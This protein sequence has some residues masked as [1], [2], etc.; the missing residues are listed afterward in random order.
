MD[1]PDENLRKRLTCG[2]ASALAEAYDAHGPAVYGVAYRVLADPHIAEDVAHDVF[3]SLWESPGDYNPRRGRL[4]PWL[5]ALARSR[6]IDRVRQAEAERRRLP[7]MAPNLSDTED[8]AAAIERDALVKAVRNAID[9]LP[10]SQR[11]GIHLAYYRGLSYRQVAAR[12]GIAEGTA[13]SRM[14]A[15]LR[16]L[17]D[18]LDAEDLI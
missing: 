3:L 18:R 1:D 7:V 8:V 9:D 6:A 17:A 4:R 16:Q 10:E 5:C 15:A 2:D 13:K 12:L 11:A 14:R